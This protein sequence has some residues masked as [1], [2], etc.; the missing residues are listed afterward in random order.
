MRFGM[1]VQ[2]DSCAQALGELRDLEP[3]LDPHF[4]WRSLKDGLEFSGGARRKRGET[5]LIKVI[6]R[7]FLQSRCR[8]VASLLPL[9]PVFQARR[10]GQHHAWSHPPLDRILVLFRPQPHLQLVQTLAALG[11]PDPSEPSLPLFDL[12]ADSGTH[13]VGCVPS[14]LCSAAFSGSPADS[15]PT[16]VICSAVGFD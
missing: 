14:T 13:S 16:S 9:S 3:L 1:G 2:T 12:P 4:R 7:R 5:H 11:L 8:I 15:E 6:A 10:W